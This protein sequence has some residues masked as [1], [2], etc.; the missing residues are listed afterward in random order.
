M[1][2]R[3]EIIFKLVCLKIFVLLDVSSAQ[4]INI[5]QNLISHLFLHAH[6]LDANQSETKRIDNDL[7]INATS[8]QPKSD[9]VVHK[10]KKKSVP[11]NCDLSEREMI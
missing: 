5:F 11:L 8:F 3:S 9:K 1:I 2:R 4:S 10:E 7:N 6:G